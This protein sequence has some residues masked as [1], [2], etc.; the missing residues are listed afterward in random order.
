[1]KIK[2]DGEHALIRWAH[3][4]YKF[5]NTTSGRLIS[6][7]VIEMLNMP[8]IL[9]GLHFERDMG[10]YFE[11]TSRWHG[12]PG[13]LDN[14]PG[15]RSMELHTLWFEFVCPWW[16][17]SL[18]EPEALN[19]KE[20]FEAIDRLNDE[21]K[22]EMKRKQ[23]RKGIKAGYNQIVKLSEILLSVPV[24]FAALTDWKKGPSLARAIVHIVKKIEEQ[25]TWMKYTID[26]TWGPYNE[27]NSTD[28]QMFN[29]I[30]KNEKDLCHYFQQFGLG[31]ECVK[32]NLKALTLKRWEEKPPNYGLREFKVEYEFLFECLEAKFSLLPSSTR[33]VEQKHGQ[34]RHS[35]QLMAGHD[36]TDSQQQYVTN[37]DYE[38]KEKRRQVA[39]KRKAENEDPNISKK[40]KM[41]RGVAGC[42]HDE[43]KE[44]Q[45]QVGKDLMEQE[46]LYSSDI[47]NKYPDHVKEAAGVRNI[48]K[49]GTT[50]R[51]RELKVE[52]VE[53]AK[54]KEKRSRIVVPT[55]DEFKAN[56][57]DLQVD[58]DMNWE[59]VGEEEIEKRD[60]I[61]KLK[62]FTFWNK[63]SKPQLLD[64]TK[65]VFP[66]LWDDSFVS[67]TK[68]KVTT[69]LIK[70][71]LVTT[72]GVDEINRNW[73]ECEYLK[74][75]K[76]Q[77]KPKKN[78]FYL[79]E[80]K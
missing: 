69:S 19:F 53:N 78:C 1:M 6:K 52:K 61:K 68:L 33:I 40:R 59:D 55:L 10:K 43:G 3:S 7:D 56:S 67:F 58:N 64:D 50:S 27:G 51:N 16:N 66:S 13:C 25:A 12:Q 8:D 4:C 48:S 20:T 42:K 5:S 39:R 77:K 60:S 75:K 49:K 30:V 29:L 47:I 2:I 71:H 74:K 22:K 11:V 35:L 73:G 44:L 31:M 23:V 70:Q 76:I 36:F 54:E 18:K 37:I 45:I 62:T 32:N 38:W 57:Q 24:I 79:V 46:K 14:R 17:G 65:N 72:M 26:D 34:L 80:I 41:S 28:K 21:T 63:L 15:F 9:I